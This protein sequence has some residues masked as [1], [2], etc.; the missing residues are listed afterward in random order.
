MSFAFFVLFYFANIGGGISEN[1]HR[2]LYVGG[3]GD[4]NYSSIQN[5]INEANSGDTIFVYNGTYKE[6]LV[7]DKSIILIGESREK[8]II[9]GCGKEVVN[10]SANYVELR[11][12]N[13]TNGS[14]GVKIS[15]SYNILE[16]CKIC[17]NEHALILYFS[18]E[19]LIRNNSLCFNEGNAVALYGSTKNVIEKC[20]IISNGGGIDIISSHDNVIKNNTIN[21]KTGYGIFLLDAQNMVITDNDFINDSIYFSNADNSLKDFNHKIENNIING[22]PYYYYGKKDFTVPKNAGA[23]ILVE[24]ENVIVNGV[25]ITHADCGIEIAFCK[26]ITIKNSNISHNYWFPAIQLSYSNDILFKNN[27]IGKGG[28]IFLVSSDKNRI[29]NNKIETGIYFCDSD[30][31][32]IKNNTISTDGI[33]LNMWY[34]NDGTNNYNIIENNFISHAKKGIELM[35]ASHNTIKNNV[36]KSNKIGI[37]IIYGSQNNMIQ[38]NR[39]TK[40]QEGM[41]IEVND[42]FVVPSTNNFIYY[43][44]FIDNNLQ[45]FDNCNNYWDDGNIGNYWSDYD[46]VDIN[47]DEIGDMPYY[48][49]GGKNADHYPLIEPFETF[50][51]IKK[52]SEGFLYVFDREL[53]SLPIDRALIIGEITVKALTMGVNKVEFYVDDKLMK[54]DDETPYEWKWNCSSGFHTLKVIGYGN[55]SYADTI[56]VLGFI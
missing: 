34:G 25:E 6:N 20:E 9:N 11:G 23:I 42:E 51:M 38:S 24:C 28:P 14:A 54:V 36:L 52:P 32:V 35:G 26:N 41:V 50:L 1:T 40:N 8:T 33:H 22:K 21:S 45:A 46:G 48:I 7:I 49:S 55:E 18:E 15:S 56:N 30:R 27:N 3:G 37:H 12:L 16:N 39:F 19:N 43:N 47:G 17:G 13:I 44:K 10:I 4:G 53:M 2:T 29:E 31:V 5:A